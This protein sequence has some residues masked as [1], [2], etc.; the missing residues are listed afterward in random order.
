MNQDLDYVF[1]VTFGR[2]GS[3]LLMNLLNSLDGYDI[4]GENAN[5]LFHLYKSF[6]SSKTTR[7]NRGPEAKNAVSPW[8]GASAVR[9]QRYL[10]Q[11]RSLFEAE[12]LQP[13]DETRVSGF[14]EIRYTSNFMSDAEFNEYLDFLI[15]QF[16][17]TKIV[18]NT[19]DTEAVMQSGWWPRRNP[20]RAR[21]L[22][23]E[24][25]TRFETYHAKRP[26]K[27]I[28]VHYDR[29]INDRSEIQRL[30]TFLDEPYD[31]AKVAEVMSRKYSVGGRK[32]ATAKRA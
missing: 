15:E 2:S 8:N 4:K 17:N 13:T 26:D 14:K 31:E 29:Y 24:A 22:I 20:K 30:F 21:T 32:P 25:L 19:R 9:P 23:T 6:L 27:T 1:V 11:L 28:M 10:D 7:K 3:T 18:F 5:A 12:F 16:N